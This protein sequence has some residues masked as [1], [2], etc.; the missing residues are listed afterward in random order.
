MK[1]YKG[2]YS[3]GYYGCDEEFY[4]TAENKDE[5][6]QIFDEGKQLYSFSEPDDR[7]ISLDIEPDEEGYD[8]AYDEAY[9]DYQILINENSWF[10]E[11]TKEEYEEEAE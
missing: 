8:E 4:F 6:D 11:I 1:Y 2:T 3:N 5:A 7:F 9:E 10:E